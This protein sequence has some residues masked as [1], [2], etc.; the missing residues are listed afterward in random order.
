MLLANQR[1]QQADWSGACHE[2]RMRLPQCALAD[3]EDLLPG[4]RDDGRGLHQHAEQAEGRVDLHRVL[5]LDSP[6]LRHEAIDFLDAALGVLA[7]AA[8]V[9]FT[10]RAVWAGHGVGAADDADDQVTYAK[11][12][13]QTR[14]DD[15]AERLVAEYKPRLSRRC[16]AVLALDDLDVGAA[17]AGG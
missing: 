10:D 6:A 5:R 8:H 9:P 11:R 7:V 12:A 13:G 4:L 15:A 17:D 14:L 3:R 16:P 1:R 2:H